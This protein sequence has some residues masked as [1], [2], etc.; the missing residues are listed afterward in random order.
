MKTYQIQVHSEGYEDHTK[1]VQ[2]ANE[3][4]ARQQERAAKVEWCELNDI[5]IDTDF[6][7]PF[8]RIS[9]I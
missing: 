8:T 3:R 9:R 5:D 6:E 7:L 2:A 1:I 4:Q